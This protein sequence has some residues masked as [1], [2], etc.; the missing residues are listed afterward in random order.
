MAVAGFFFL[1]YA[2][3]LLAIPRQLLNVQL[4]LLTRDGAEPSWQAVLLCRL[5]GGVILTVW[6]LASILA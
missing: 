4:M 6:A 1:L 3:A 5:T 2:L